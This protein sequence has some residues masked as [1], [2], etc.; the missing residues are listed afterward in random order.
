LERQFV[1]H[2]FST[3]FP[4]SAKSLVFPA[5]YADEIHVD[6]FGD[7]GL[8]SGGRGKP[9]KIGVQVNFVFWQ[10]QTIVNPG[11]QASLV[12][13]AIGGPCETSAVYESNSARVQSGTQR[14]KPMD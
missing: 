11:I 4:E 1:R 14:P 6:P 2:E 12:P 9:G 10:K 7:F 3:Q 8:Y 5:V 13:T